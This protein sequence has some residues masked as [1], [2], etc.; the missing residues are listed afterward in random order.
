MTDRDQPAVEAEPWSLQAR[1]E[2]AIHN[3]S[4]GIVIFDASRKV[5]FCNRRYMDMYGLA[6]EQVKPGTPTSAL[7][8]HR[9]NIGLKV[10]V[11]PEDYIRERV[12]RDIA[13]DTTV[14]E[15]TDGRIIAYT[16]RP[17]PDGG[18]IATHEDITEREELNA[19]L[20]VRNFQ[21]DTAINNMS[22]GLCFFDADHKLIVANDRFLEMYDIPPGK[23]GPG[24]PLTEIVDLRFEAGSFPAMSRDEYLR[25]RV[26]VAVSNEAKDSIV[27]LR[28]GKTFKI[29]HRPM[30]D[31]GW[32]ATHEDITE[33]RRAEVKIEHMAH[34]DA[35]TD[36]ANRALLNE[37]LEQSLGRSHDGEMV[38][39]HH[40]DLDQFK[41]VN[42]TF[43]HPAGDKL[44]KIVAD[45][46]HD[47]VAVEPGP[48]L[49]LTPRFWHIAIAG[50]IEPVPSPPLAIMRRG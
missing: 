6:P 39:V 43:G 20:K 22:Q 12:G 5:V 25:W 50:Q 31:L 19:R 2:E 38:A 40:L 18:G 47:P 28:N 46:L 36:L 45:R 30:P 8:Q 44:L 13:L 41:A 11:A 16:V 1:L 15:F 7:I 26:N 34:H 10:R 48:G 27:E 49:P 29:R 21:F 24:T 3:L 33:Q 35:L 9:L 14:Q 23:V 32:V 37:R 17:L 42:D 4:L